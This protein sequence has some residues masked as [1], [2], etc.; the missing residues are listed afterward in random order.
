MLLQVVSRL[1]SVGGLCFLSIVSL[2]GN[3]ALH[4]QKCSPSYIE[5]STFLSLVTHLI[6]TVPPMIKIPAQVVSAGTVPF[7]IFSCR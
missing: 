6:L 7:V 1:Q 2:I 5:R 3:L 4:Q